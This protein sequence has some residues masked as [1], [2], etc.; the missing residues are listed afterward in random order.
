MAKK[1]SGFQINKVS[2]YSAIVLGAYYLALIIV[3]AVDMYGYLEEIMWM[4]M[5]GALALAVFFAYIA[6]NFV[7]HKPAIYK[8]V[9]LFIIAIIAVG[10]IL[11][12]CL[13]FA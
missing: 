9:Y 11:P 5:A 10:I 4:G 3:A 7:A 2:F 6:W 12:P 8:I 13:L 1:N